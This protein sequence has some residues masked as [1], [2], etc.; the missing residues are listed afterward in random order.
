M[1]TPTRGD[2]EKCSGVLQFTRTHS[3]VPTSR[4]C[5]S[6]PH[7]ETLKVTSPSEG[8]VQVELNRP[9]KSNAMN[10]AFWRLASERERE[11]EGGRGREREGEGR[12][13]T[14]LGLDSLEHIHV[15]SFPDTIR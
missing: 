9:S 6:L 13:C 1:A 4:L 14:W 5:S 12:R 8:V 11:G 3:T 10:R 15:V 7:Y 2:C